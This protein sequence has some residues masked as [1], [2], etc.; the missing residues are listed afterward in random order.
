M[1]LDIHGQKKKMNNI[2]FRTRDLLVQQNICF[3]FFAPRLICTVIFCF[4]QL[5]HADHETFKNNLYCQSSQNQCNE[6]EKTAVH[7]HERENSWLIIY[8]I[9]DQTA[10]MGTYRI[11]RTIT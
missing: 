11:S 8:N 10:V 1:V 4:K 9:C 7:R 3:K 6:E 5:E 2:V